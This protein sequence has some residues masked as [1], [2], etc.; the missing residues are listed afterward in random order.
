MY[1]ISRFPALATLNL[2]QIRKKEREAAERFYL[3]WCRSTYLES[4]GA[5]FLKQIPYYEEYLERH[6][7]VNASS[8]HAQKA[9]KLSSKLMKITLQC[10]ETKKSKEKKLPGTMQVSKLKLLSRRLFRLDKRA[11]ITL[12]LTSKEDGHTMVLDGESLPL[13]QYP[14]ASGDTIVVCSE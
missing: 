1:L 8:A 10:D 14:I 6:G 2:S 4:K 11:D 13:R 9:A 7:V 12:R 3:K 5:A